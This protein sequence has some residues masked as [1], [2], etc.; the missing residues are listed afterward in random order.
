MTTTLQCFASAAS[1]CID[2]VE[3][4][5]GAIALVGDSFVRPLIL[6]HAR[7]REALAAGVS[8]VEASMTLCLA[9]PSI[10]PWVNTNG[11]ASMLRL[12]QD[13]YCQPGAHAGLARLEEKLGEAAA[14]HLR[15]LG[16]Q[17]DHSREGPGVAGVLAAV[18]ACAAAALS[19]QD[20]FHPVLFGR[21][22]VDALRRESDGSFALAS[23]DDGESLAEVLLLVREATDETQRLVA[24]ASSELAEWFAAGHHKERELGDLHQWYLCCATASEEWLREEHRREAA[25]FALS[26]RVMHLQKELDL[27]VDEENLERL[28]FDR[29]WGKFLPRAGFPRVCEAVAPIA[30]RSQ[31]NEFH[32]TRR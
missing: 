5:S 15:R 24:E 18:R 7:L 29:R 8:L 11:V 31:G 23:V 28:E 21:A 12:A 16:R 20:L 30:I 3:L 13:T 25:H 26:Q 2:A 22:A 27:A 9:V 1:D 4:Y 17:G 6:E 32:Q 14:R 19:G 10:S